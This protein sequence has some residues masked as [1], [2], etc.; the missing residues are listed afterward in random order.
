MDI[1][2]LTIMAHGWAGKL[3]ASAAALL[4]IVAL[5]RWLDRRANIDF[6]EFAKD[7]KDDSTAAAFYLGLRFLGASILVGLVV[8]FS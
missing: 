3:M 5:L 4:L 8:A 2:L 6:R 7:L 1:D